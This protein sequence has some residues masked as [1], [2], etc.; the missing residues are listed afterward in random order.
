MVKIWGRTN[1][2]NVQKVLWTLAE[3]NEPFDR[4][5]AGLQ[6][7]VNDTEEFRLMN[8]NGLVPVLQEDDF[9]LW[10]SHAIMRYLAL[11]D[12]HRKLLP[13]DGHSA[14]IVDQWL[15]WSSTTVWPNMKPVFRNMVRLPKEQWN[16]QAIEAGV[17][18]LNN[19][20]QILTQ[21]LTNLPYV[22]GE[23][24]SLADIPLAL[25]VHRWYLLDIER[26]ELPVVRQWYE[27][28]AERPAFVKYCDMPLS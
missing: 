15:E 27:R 5:D 14:A 4:I 19:D 7:G 13:A 23:Y 8:P 21:R 16:K 24:F 25:I 6:Y 12:P 26:I 9:A 17:V 20:M 22:A 28:V 2:I 18:G 10:E 11:R 3:I 1:S